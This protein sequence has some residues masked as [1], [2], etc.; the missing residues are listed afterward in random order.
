MSIPF[1]KATN[2]AKTEAGFNR[3]TKLDDCREV[4]NAVAA[5]PEGV[6][7]ELGQMNLDN[8]RCVLFIAAMEARMPIKTRI[9][10]TKTHLLVTRKEVA[11]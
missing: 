1:V 5:N 9:S 8:L 11:K 7:I 6:L 10:P 4:I 3:R 2:E